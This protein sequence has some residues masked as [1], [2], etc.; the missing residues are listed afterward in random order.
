[1]GAAVLFL[2]GKSLKTNEG[3]N[4]ALKALPSLE[5]HRELKFVHKVIEI[6]VNKLPLNLHDEAIL[7]K[8][9]C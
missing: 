2:K 1:M 8:F 4:L 6:G 5:F 9:E 7:E 3:I